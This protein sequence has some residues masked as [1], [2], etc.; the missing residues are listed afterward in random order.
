MTAEKQQSQRFVADLIKEDRVVVGGCFGSL[1]IGDVGEDA[2]PRSL[3]PEGVDRVVPR[4]LIEPTGGV[5]GNAMAS[6]GLQGL[7]QRVLNNIL[8]QVQTRDPKRPRQQTDE[9]A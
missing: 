2:V 8:D 1:K 5:V 3:A 6:P 9:P 4:G 7:H